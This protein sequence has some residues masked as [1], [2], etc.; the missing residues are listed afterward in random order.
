MQQHFV[1]QVYLRQWCDQ[2]GQ[3]I[4]YCRVGPPGA[5]TLRHYP[6]F[7]SQVFREDDL[8]SLPEGGIAN[9]RR[10]DEVENLLGR[11]IEESLSS[12]IAACDGRSRL[13]DSRA[14]DQVKW[15]MQ[16]FVARSPSCLAAIEAEMVA[17]SAQHEPMIRRTLER[18]RTPKF[19]AELAQYMDP[20]FPSVA[21]RAGLAGIAETEQVPMP[22]WYDGQVQVL[23]AESVR[24][25]LNSLGIDHFVTFEEP[26]MHWDSN[27]VGLIASFSLSPDLLAFVLE[28]PCEE[29]WPLALRHLVYS[30]RHRSRAICRSTA[31]NGL[32]LAQAQ[33]LVPWIPPQ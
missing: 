13:L 21:A 5:P 2:H 9:G 12:I 32:W 3:L 4:L 25:M 8:Y 28:K 17:W 18:L 14:S 10:G 29:D 7:P 27:A 16:T 31:I 30:L 1:P 6:K 23:R 26:V 22:G 20:R 33:H 15:L 11:K 24:P 19:E